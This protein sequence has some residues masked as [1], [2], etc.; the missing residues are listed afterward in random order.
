MCGG[1]GS[2]GGEEREGEKGRKRKRS[3]MERYLILNG[4]LFMNVWLIL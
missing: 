1:W 4:C 3:F 2:G